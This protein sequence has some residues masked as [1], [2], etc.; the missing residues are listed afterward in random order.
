M[1]DVLRTKVL[2]AV[3]CG[4]ERGGTTLLSRI[5]AE[6]PKLDSGFESGL[7]L[8]PSPQAFLGR[9]YKTYNGSLIKGG[10]G[11]DEQDLE[12]IC[13]AQSWNQAYL[14]LRARSR[15]IKDKNAL[16]FDKTPAYMKDLDNILIKMD[17][18]KAVV[19]IK[20]PLGVIWSWIKREKNPKEVSDDRIRSFCSRYLSYAEGYHKALRNHP[21]RILMIKFSDLCLDPEAQVR[22]I[23]DHLLLDFY[24]S[25]LNYKPKYE[26]HGNR[27]D[28]S[29]IDQY[30]QGLTSGQIALIRKETAGIFEGY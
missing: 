7:L 26:V 29:F 24:P 11:I 15:L 6:H 17:G 2:R 25:M 27:I 5:L 4:Y 21:K 9:A 8:A 22:R 19:I 30:K 28:T 1:T 12:Y 18:I 14:R 10:W 23:C 3:L 20:Q 16:L 13:S